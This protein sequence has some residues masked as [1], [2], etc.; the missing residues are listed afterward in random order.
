MWRSAPPPGRDHRVA[1]PAVLV[2][3][4]R[5]DLLEGLHI[6]HAVALDAHGD[7]VWSVGDP[8]AIILP[9]SAIKPV[10]AAA[11]LAAGADLSGEH[12][13]I[14]TSSHSGE[15][16]QLALVAEVLARADCTTEALRCPA[17]LPY[18]AS[19]MADWL[20]AGRQPTPLAMNCS[21][22]HAAMLLA[23]RGQGW[24]MDDY[25]HAEHP[26][27]MTV[28]RLLERAGVRIAGVTVDGC[29]AP[30]FALPLVDLARL[31]ATAVTADADDPELG[32]LR[33]VADA[34]RAHPQVVGGVDRDVTA[35]MKGVPGLL[36]KEGA[37]GVHAGALPDGRAFACKVLDGSMAARTPI[38]MAL[39]AALA[40]DTSAVAMKAALT[41]PTVWGGGAPVGYLDSVWPPMSTDDWGSRTAR[42][43]PESA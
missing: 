23:C 43:R 35:L 17:E 42:T 27:Q 26:M 41:Q 4:W 5:G 25:L 21:G 33:R 1:E 32:V 38:V 12:L 28:R 40:V 3:Q 31:H 8:E 6:G 14:A 15:P 18:G 22:K 37:A 10:Q 16:A 2:R 20:R 13:A 34:A 11:T 29:G 36:T 19:T 30:L 9:R 24:S 39:L 7:V